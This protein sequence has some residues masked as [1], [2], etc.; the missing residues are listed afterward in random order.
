[1]GG[2]KI[3]NCGCKIYEHEKE[4]GANHIHTEEFCESCYEEQKNKTDTLEQKLEELLN[5]FKISPSNPLVNKIFSIEKQLLVKDK[6]SSYNT[7]CME[8]IHCPCCN[9]KLQYNNL[10]KHKNS[11]G[12]INNLPEKNTE[13]IKEKKDSNARK[14]TCIKANRIVKQYNNKTISKEEA[15]S[16]LKDLGINIKFV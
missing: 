4:W 5:K 9:K 3:L 13:I 15:N 1:M 12:H 8:E 16:K 2:S 7:Y 6:R 14:Q 11:L 10:E